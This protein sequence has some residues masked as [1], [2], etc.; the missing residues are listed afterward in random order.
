MIYHFITAPY[1][2]FEKLSTKWRY[3]DLETREQH[4]GSPDLRFLA[5]RKKKYIETPW[6]NSSSYPENHE[7]ST[8]NSLPGQKSFLFHTKLVSLSGSSGININLVYKSSVI[9]SSRGIWTVKYF[10]NDNVCSRTSMLAMATNWWYT[11]AALIP[12]DMFDCQGNPRFNVHVGILQLTPN[13][14]IIY[15]F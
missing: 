4:F 10:E 11:I 1:S 2:R 7:D 8:C 9:V 12:H 13:N 5:L 6:Q 14:N 15:G 3:L